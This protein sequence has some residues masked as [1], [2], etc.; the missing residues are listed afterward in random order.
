[1]RSLASGLAKRGRMRPADTKSGLARRGTTSRA[2]RMLP[3]LG[4]P[5]GAPMRPS[6]QEI[7]D[8][9]Q[10]GEAGRLVYV[11][12]SGSARSRD[13][14]QQRDSPP[15][16]RGPGSPCATK[17]RGREGPQSRRGAGAFQ[18][19]GRRSRCAGRRPVSSRHQQSAVE[20]AVPTTR[21]DALSPETYPRFRSQRRES[22]QIRSAEAADYGELDFPQ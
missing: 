12:T 8:A 1:M 4:K 2:E 3:F 18:D 6:Y 20:V 21:S 14:D 13:S 5:T 17:P 16:A 11:L 9:A 15:A 19:V 7:I 10:A 22:Q